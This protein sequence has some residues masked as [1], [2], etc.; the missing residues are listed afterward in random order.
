MTAISK[1]RAAA[2]QLYP[3]LRRR[4]QKSVRNKLLLIKIIIRPAM[5]YAST[6]WMAIDALLFVRNSAI[7]RDW[8]WEPL[9][10]FLQRKAAS[11]YKTAEN[12]PFPEVRRAVDYA[13]SNEGP[14]KKSPMQHMAKYGNRCKQQTAVYKDISEK[15][16]P[17]GCE[18]HFNPEEDMDNYV[19]FK[20]MGAPESLQNLTQDTIIG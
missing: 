8:E 3:L 13:P 12:Y 4:G 2:S 1:A 9:Q 16:T 18:D 6:I 7:H 20:L 10:D 11:T 15:T 5:S 14:R 17:H 19:K